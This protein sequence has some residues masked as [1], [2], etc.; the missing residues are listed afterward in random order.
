MGLTLILA[1][2]VFVAALAVGIAVGLRR[3][4]IAGIASGF[5]VLALGA[6]GYVVLV[7]LMWSM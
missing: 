1:A 6:L 7:S 4:A 2:V 5:G 3:G